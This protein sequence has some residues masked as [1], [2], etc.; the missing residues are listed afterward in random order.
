MSGV[1]A[2]MRERMVAFIVTILQHLTLV[3][4]F[5][6]DKIHYPLYHI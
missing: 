2:H 3:D 6:V 5:T 4:D 1:M